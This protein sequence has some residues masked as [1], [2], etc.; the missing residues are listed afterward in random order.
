MATIAPRRPETAI[1][2]GYHGFLAFCEVIDLPLE[3]YLR[4][5]SRAYHSQAREV[6]AILPSGCWKTSLGSAIALHHLTSTPGA[7][8]CDCRGQSSLAAT[9]PPPSRRA[10]LGLIRECAR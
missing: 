4:R 3:P 2:P 10:R 6:V 9:W 8:V 1:K 7:S 5:I